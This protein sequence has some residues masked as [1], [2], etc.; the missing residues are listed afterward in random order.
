MP[1]PGLAAG[2]PR[3]RDPG[4]RR[5]E[6]L[7]PPVPRPRGR[8]SG[9]AAVIRGAG[10]GTLPPEAL[11]VWLSPC[12]ICVIGGREERGLSTWRPRWGVA[13]VRGPTAERAPGAWPWGAVAL[14]VRAPPPAAPALTRGHGLRPDVGGDPGPCN[15]AGHGR[16]AGDPRSPGGRLLE[17]QGGAFWERLRKAPGHAA[18][19]GLAD[20]VLPVQAAVVSRPALRAARGGPD[21]RQQE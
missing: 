11:Q 5:R 13:V 4:G 18:S 14:T 16:P 7:G 15:G 6:A 10:D 21:R 2:G 3:R 9:R 19:P 17:L 8:R 1:G 12:P 20:W